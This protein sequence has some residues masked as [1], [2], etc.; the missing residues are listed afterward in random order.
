M[1]SQFFGLN[2]A[3]SGLRNANAALL[4][5]GNNVA[6]SNTDGYSRQK[7]KSEAADALRVFT[8]YGC[9]GAGVETL[10]IERVRD[11][12]YDNRFRQNETFLGKYEQ[13]DYYNELIEYYF[14]D[15]NLTGTGFTSL[16]DRMGSALQTILTTGTDDA[17]TSYFGAVK[18]LTDYFNNNAGNLEKLQETVNE[19][20][21]LVCN[22]INAC[23]SKITILNDQI[24]KIE[25]N[26]ANANEL[27][28]KRDLLLDEL[29]GYVSIEVRETKVRDTNDPDRDTGLTRMEIH[30]CGGD[31][32][33]DGTEYNQMICIARDSDERINQSDIDGLYD[34]RWAGSKFDENNPIFKGRFNLGNQLIG[35][36][37][38]GLIDVRDGNNGQYFHGKAAG[39]EIEPT[40]AA[41]MDA[42][43][44]ALKV[45][46]IPSYLKD[47]AKSSL[48]E[49]STITIGPRT[50]HYSGWE[51]NDDNTYTF[52]IIPPEREA[53][54][55]YL[56][57]DASA[58][59]Q[60]P[61]EV[62]IGASVNFQ[63]VPYYM[64]QMN[65]WIRNYSEEVNYILT[66]GYTHDSRDGIY[67]LTGKMT[68]DSNAQYSFQDLTGTNK[69]YSY[70]TAQNF[71]INDTLA[72]NPSLLATKSDKTEGN[73]QM[74]NLEKLK[75]MNMTK[76][77]F[78]NTTSGKFLEKVLADI[79]LNKNNS[80]TMV[81]TYGDLQKTIDNQRLS[82]SGVDKDEEALSLVE[83]QNLYTLSSKM[84]QTLTEIYDRL[85][86]QTGV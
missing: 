49:E 7:V 68:T 30:I 67:M 12:F 5:T 15:D 23:A 46:D 66:T 81:K 20:I 28:D 59:K 18:S 84:F 26:G 74:G 80:A 71:A 69:R 50:Y 24:N 53:D 73:E 9:A 40:G 86:L 64:S 27:R 22:S 83:Y 62:S 17:K 37:L 14:A 19:E 31:L 85:I 36:K 3:A 32:L 65:E 38:Q 70:L 4:T 61:Y 63:G 78:R 13:R 42:T 8:K 21:K 2:I 33:V 16:Y 58:S 48:F 35:G 57:A 56:L 25:N 60:P 52:H 55:N 10:A 39:I 79:T 45:D 34:I 76:P 44:F 1:P 11:Q 75:D 6:N 77:V 47:M 43:S 29:S 82:V 51:F 41:V 54:R 72:G